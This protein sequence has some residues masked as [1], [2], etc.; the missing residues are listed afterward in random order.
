MDPAA[1]SSE[2]P[3]AN[4]PGIEDVEL[5]RLGLD[6]A[7]LAAAHRAIRPHVHRTPVVTCRHLDDALG[8]QLFLKCENLQRTGAF[9]LRGATHALLHLP[10]HVR[11]RGVV[12]HS[13]GNHGQALALAARRLGAPAT[14]VVP[15]GAPVVK[16]TAVEG[17]GARVMRCAP[18][19]AAREAAAQTFVDRYGL[20]LIPPYD[21]PHIV[22]GQGTAALELLR[23]VPDLD[24]V[25][26]P[27][28]GGGLLAGTALAARAHRTSTGV[29]GARPRVWGVEP[30][31]ADDAKRSLESGTRQ[32]MTSPDTI[33]D[34][35]RTRIGVLPFRVLQRHVDGI[36]AV[37]DTATIAAMRF[38]W[39]RTK[40]LIEAS[41]AI[42]IA[43]QLDGTLA[44][45]GIDVRGK[46]IGVIVSGG[47]VDLD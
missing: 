14:V 39:T 15:E 13:S 44:D 20:T 24:L 4:P 18:T 19:L 47:N 38:L 7:G 5:V 42:A 11:A 21:H 3:S 43:A 2:Q 33:C 10:T 23:D 32:P 27:V 46:R 6:G 12:T 36:A 9:K 26:A 34:G 30:A 35:L 22:A 25:L 8:A 1:T 37:D 29:S 17:Y 16:A 28:G 45:E 40:L 31:G 41:A